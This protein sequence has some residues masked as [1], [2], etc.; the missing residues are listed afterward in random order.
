MDENN[1]VINTVIILT[2]GVKESCGFTSAMIFA[3]KYASAIPVMIPNRPPIIVMIADSD[4][5]AFYRYSL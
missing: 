2:E 3:T 4:K 5:K 1:V